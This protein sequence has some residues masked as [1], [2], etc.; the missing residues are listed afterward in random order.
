MC[1][2]LFLN[3]AVFEHK[4]I[5]FKKREKYFKVFVQIADMVHHVKFIFHS[6][7]TQ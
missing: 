7:K 2:I 6:F 1:L 5:Q 4:C 3:I